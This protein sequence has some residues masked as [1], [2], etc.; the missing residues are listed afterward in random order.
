MGEGYKKSDESSNFLGSVEER[1]RGSQFCLLSL[2]SGNL[3]CALRMCSGLLI[4]LSPAHCCSFP[5]PNTGRTTWAWTQSTGQCREETLRNRIY[6]YLSIW[7][8]EMKEGIERWGTLQRNLRSPMPRGPI[9]KSTV[10]LTMVPA[11]AV[12]LTHTHS[13]PLSFSLSL[14]LSLSHPHSHPFLVTVGRLS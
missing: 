10:I 8:L 5:T 13:P 2:H 9:P 3:A 4:M 12:D 11:R 6:R 1:M 14:S 7:Y